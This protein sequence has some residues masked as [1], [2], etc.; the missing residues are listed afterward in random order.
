VITV[1]CY[2]T[3]ILQMKYEMKNILV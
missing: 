3:Q 2:E 1:N